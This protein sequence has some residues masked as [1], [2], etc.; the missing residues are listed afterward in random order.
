MDVLLDITLPPN[1]A[2]ITGLMLYVNSPP[3]IVSRRISDKEKGHLKN[4]DKIVKKYS[5]RFHFQP[6]SSNL[7]FTI[8]KSSSNVLGRF[9]R[10]TFAICS[11]VLPRVRSNL[12]PSGSVL[13]DCGFFPFSGEK[14]V[15]EKI[16]EEQ[17]CLDICLAKIFITR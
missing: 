16:F 17:K 5:N 8:S 9:F 6:L 13:V 11:N 2:V 1:L 10:E 14:I 12:T 4:Y 15:Q 3:K 7:R